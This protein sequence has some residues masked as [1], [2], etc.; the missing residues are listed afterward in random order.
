MD[1]KIKCWHS[2]PADKIAVNNTKM[3]VF[4]IDWRGPMYQP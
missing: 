3:I 4:V 1:T 2:E